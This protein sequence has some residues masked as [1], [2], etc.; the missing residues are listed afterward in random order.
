MYSCNQIC[1]DD[2][3]D[4]ASIMLLATDAVMFEMLATVP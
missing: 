4:V 2:C 3:M 1:L